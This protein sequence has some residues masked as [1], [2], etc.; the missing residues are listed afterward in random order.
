MSNS[1]C[2]LNEVMNEED[3]S[4]GNWFDNKQKEGQI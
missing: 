4:H 2:I 3:V 1:N